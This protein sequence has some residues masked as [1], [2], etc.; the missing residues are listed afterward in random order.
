MCFQM[1]CMDVTDCWPSSSHRVLDADFF[2]ILLFLGEFVLDDLPDINEDEITGAHLLDNETFSALNHDSYM[3][4]NDDEA[5]LS[6]LTDV[7]S[8]GEF[9]DLMPE[10]YTD[11]EY[12]LS[13]IEDIEKELET[14]IDNEGGSETLVNILISYILLQLNLY[15]LEPSLKEELTEFQM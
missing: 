8:P 9:P 4:F 3:P 2:K 14:Y 5:Q 11:S 10:N 1:D 7:F 15:S 12:I 13:Q 6:N